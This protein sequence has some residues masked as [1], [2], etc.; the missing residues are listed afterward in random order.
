M[1]RGIVGGREKQ[2]LGSSTELFYITHQN[3]LTGQTKDFSCT[4]WYAF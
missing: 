1:A 3:D 4:L 2:V